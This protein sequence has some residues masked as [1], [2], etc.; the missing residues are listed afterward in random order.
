MERFW[1]GFYFVFS[2][3]LEEKSEESVEREA[4]WGLSRGWVGCLDA[5]RLREREG[6]NL[7]GGK[8]G[9]RLVGRWTGQLEKGR[10][11][12]RL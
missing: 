2:L 9:Q 7:K 5:A 6:E 12:A 4:G 11:S 1:S 8:A 10:P 3:F